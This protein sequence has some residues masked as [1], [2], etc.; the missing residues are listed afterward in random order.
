[1]S[2]KAGFGKDELKNVTAK[3]V[4]RVVGCSRK[5]VYNNINNGKGKYYERIIEAIR[6]I[7]ESLFLS[8][9]IQGR[10]EV[11]DYDKEAVTA[12]IVVDGQKKGIDV[13]FT[14]D[15]LL[16]VAMAFG[17]LSSYFDPKIDGDHYHAETWDHRKVSF[18][19]WWE[20]I[21]DE[22]N[23]ERYFE[24]AVIEAARDAMKRVLKDSKIGLGF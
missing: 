13:S 2:N 5:T 24:G 17:D 9:I 18:P 4:A 12:T 15:Y 16:S 6:T 1:M 19:E 22:T 23:R 7:N 20:E 14:Q 3:A 10:F 21:V 11:V 8:Q